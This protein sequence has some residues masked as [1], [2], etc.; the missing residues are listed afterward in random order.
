MGCQGGSPS[1]FGTYDIYKTLNL[2]HHLYL[3]VFKYLPQF[4]IGSLFVHLV[5]L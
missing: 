2:L 5:F 4:L 3:T 1:P